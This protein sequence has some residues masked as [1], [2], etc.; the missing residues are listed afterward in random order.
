M[1]YRQMEIKRSREGKRQAQGKGVRWGRVQEKN[2]GYRKRG[3]HWEA[4][5]PSHRER[6]RGVAMEEKLYIILDPKA[7]QDPLISIIYTDAITPQH[8]HTS[9]SLL[10]ISLIVKHSGIFTATS[11]FYS[12]WSIP[13]YNYLCHQ[14]IYIIVNV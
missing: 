5:T 3:C 4:R 8:Y 13:N 1:S 7:S 10:L 12:N 14:F 11:L 2:V 9:F 6:P